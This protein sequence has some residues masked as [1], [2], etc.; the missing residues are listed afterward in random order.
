[1][2]AHQLLGGTN[3]DAKLD[4]P[5]KAEIL[6]AQKL[7]LDPVEVMNLVKVHLESIMETVFN[8]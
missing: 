4:K 8:D 3:L 1:M 2:F 7:G 6:T 5:T